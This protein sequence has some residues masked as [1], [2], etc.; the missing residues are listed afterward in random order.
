M[1]GDSAVAADSEAMNSRDN[2]ERISG[3]EWPV[4]LTGKNFEYEFTPFTITLVELQLH[5]D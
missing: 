3:K 4:K 2:P 5:G 1:V